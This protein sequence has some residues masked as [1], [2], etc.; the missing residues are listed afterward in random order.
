VLIGFIPFS[1]IPVK[2][3]RTAAI[4]NATA[5]D[6]MRLRCDIQILLSHVGQDGALVAKCGIKIFHRCV[7]PHI[8]PLDVGRPTTGKVLTAKARAALTENVMVVTAA[9]YP[10]PYRLHDISERRTM[11]RRVVHRA[12]QHRQNVQYF[13]QPRRQYEDVRGT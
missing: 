4:R 2:R 12:C 10:V 8:S 3:R 7:Q 5:G 1:R 11:L 6:V 13:W 9:W